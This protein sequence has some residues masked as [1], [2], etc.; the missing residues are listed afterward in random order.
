MSE[1]RGQT[2]SVSRTPRETRVTWL[3]LHCLNPNPNR[4]M[5]SPTATPIIAVRPLAGQIVSSAPLTRE[6]GYLA[7]S[8][9]TGM[10]GEPNSRFSADSGKHEIAYGARALRRRS[11]RSS[12]RTGKPSTRWA[13]VQRQNANHLDVKTVL[14]PTSARGRFACS[15]GTAHLEGKAHQGKLEMSGLTPLT[16]T[17]RRVAGGPTAEGIGGT[18]DA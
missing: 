6:G 1:K 18:R 15:Q 7:M 12:P 3:K 10:S 17:R 4:I 9:G 13:L 2:E 5:R 14:A 11:H 16:P 8:Q